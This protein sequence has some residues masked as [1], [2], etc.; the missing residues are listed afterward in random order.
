MPLL[1]QRTVVG[2]NYWTFEYDLESPG[3]TRTAFA[4]LAIGNGTYHQYNFRACWGEWWWLETTEI[5]C[6][7]LVI[8]STIVSLRLRK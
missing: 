5:V 8:L 6:F 4:T 7:V 2:R 1:V 3:F